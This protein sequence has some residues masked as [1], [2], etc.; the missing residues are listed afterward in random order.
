MGKRLQKRLDDGALEPAEYR[1]RFDGMDG[2]RMIELAC[3][4]CCYT[5]LLSST[6]SVA[7]HGVV[8][9]IWICGNEACPMSDWIS[10]EDVNE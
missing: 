8:S 2:T 6:Y 5:Q 7:P 4:S 9:P 3:P 10:L 1:L